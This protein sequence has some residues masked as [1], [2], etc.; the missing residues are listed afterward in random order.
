MIVSKTNE[1]AL[2]SC[3]ESSLLE[4]GF[5]RAGVKTKIL[6]KIMRLMKRDFGI[7]CNLHKQMN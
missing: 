3:I 1:E 7:F 4:Q 5:V 6:I 2:E